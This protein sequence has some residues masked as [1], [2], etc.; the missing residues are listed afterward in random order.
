MSDYQKKIDYAIRLIKA[1]P[2]DCEVEVGYSSGKDSDVILQLAKEAGIP[3]KAVYKNTTIDRCGSIAHA[4]EMGAKILRPKQTFFE[5][6]RYYGVP[7]RFY[8]FCCRY[9]K[10]Y[11]TGERVILGV[12]KGESQR[13]SKRYQEPEECKTYRSDMGG[14]KAKLYY[15]ILDWTNGDVE[16]FIKERGLKC[17]PHYYDEQGKFHVERRVGCMGC[18]LKTA[19]QM[20]DDFLQHPKLLKLWIKNAQIH[21]DTHP[22]ISNSVKFN[23]DAC[24]LMLF[25]LFWDGKN[26]DKFKSKMGGGIFGNEIGNPKQYLEDYFKIDL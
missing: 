21:I 18:P 15:P 20:R 10:E 13:R 5:L 9:L 11:R 17:H 8:R 7:S 24:E 25:K 4:K 6:M 14:G 26:Y 1:I 22:E 19:K 16:R 3:F 2:Q 23:H 12:R